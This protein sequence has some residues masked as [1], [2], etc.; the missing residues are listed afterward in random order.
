MNWIQI[1]SLLA[2]VAYVVFLLGN[3]FAVVPRK[4]RVAI[5]PDAQLAST[6]SIIIPCRDEESNIVACLENI[7]QQKFPAAQLEVIVADDHSADKT[8]A[9]AA[10]F[11]QQSRLAHQLLSLGESEQ[12]KKAA[13]QKAVAIASGQLILTRDADSVA[14]SDRWLY[15]L[16]YSLEKDSCDL[17]LGP[18][19]LSGDN[20]FS[21]SFQKYE[22]LAI[23]LVGA[24]MA[25]NGLPMVCSGANLAYRKSL[26]AT[27]DPYG[28]NLA[29]AS[30]DD[31]FLLKKARARAAKI[32]A[33]AGKDAVVLTPA[34]SGFRKAFS[35][36]LRW[37]SKTPHVLT[38]PVFFSGLVLL[39]GNIGSLIALVSV[40]IDGSYLGFGLFTLTIKLI[41]DFLLL[42]LSA[43][44]FSV[45][46]NPTWYLPA[47]VLNLFYTPAVAVVSVFAKP[48]WKGRR[49]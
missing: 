25:R 17:A 49:L 5:P 6:V 47:F 38:L 28:D 12:G 24:G 42:F 40:F 8:P 29:V 46:F 41:I 31:M 13:I 45:T 4:K 33:P 15:E 34:E 7:L 20:S 14:R 39:M 9:L 32:A 37:A 1:F 36:R 19:L 2:V 21:V 23:A 30:G 44:M 35:Q 48:G 27:L 3:I 11:L 16:V 26:F 18:V 22:N 10:A 43:R